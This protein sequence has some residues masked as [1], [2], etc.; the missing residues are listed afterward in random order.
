MP[1]FPFKR[2][3]HAGKLDL[4]QVEALA[5]LIHAETD[6]QRKQ[7]LRQLDGNLMKQFDLWRTRLIKI[8]ANVEAYIDFAES[9]DIEETVPNEVH[10]NILE[11]L[12]EMKI[13]LKNAKSGER[14]RKGVHVAI[15]GKH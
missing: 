3:F 4:T 10:K 12:E 1:F 15:V 9:E 11:L 13:S 7:A 8:M 6:H 2:A 14:L 5:D